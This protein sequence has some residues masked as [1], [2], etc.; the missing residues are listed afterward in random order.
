MCRLV[1]T[2]IRITRVWLCIGILPWHS[3]TGDVVTDCFAISVGKSQVR[4]AKL[5]GLRRKRRLAVTQRIEF[6]PNPPA[7]IAIA[8]SIRI[9]T[10][11]G[12]V[13]SNLLRRRWREDAKLSRKL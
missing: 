6:K 1:P 5:R 13:A 10:T 8:D 12:A 9:D 3:S 4:A 7:D 11:G 2:R